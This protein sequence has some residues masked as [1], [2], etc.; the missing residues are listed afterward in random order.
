MKLWLL[1][2]AEGV[3]WQYDAADGFVVR[4]KT[5]ADARA[6]AFERDT[7]SH[8]RNADGSTC[9]ELTADGEAEVVLESFNAG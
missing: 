8:W 3:E 5:E 7:W 1:E 4:A 9:T 6:L 2:L